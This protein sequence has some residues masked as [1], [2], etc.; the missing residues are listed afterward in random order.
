[1]DRV[2]SS[3]IVYAGYPFGE[4]R[5]QVSTLAWLLSKEH[6][7]NTRWRDKEYD[8]GYEYENIRFSWDDGDSNVR[9]MEDEERKTPIV[10]EVNVHQF[11]RGSES[12]ETPAPPATQTGPR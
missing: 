11:R 12:D 4:C 10:Y 6:T 2:G 9:R 8:E 1:M 5:V 7:E 3:W